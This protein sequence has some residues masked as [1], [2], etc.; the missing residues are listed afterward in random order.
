MCDPES[1]R[2]VKRVILGGFGIMPKGAAA[3][4]PPGCGG[5]GVRDARAR[6]A[7]VHESVSF[8][9]IELTTEDTEHT[10]EGLTR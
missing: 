6:R 8:V 9:R 7:R 4:Q 10:E 3:P 5:G 1:G 2:P